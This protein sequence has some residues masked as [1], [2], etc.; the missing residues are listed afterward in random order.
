MIVYNVHQQKTF[1]CNMCRYISVKI[2]S[3]KRLLLQVVCQTQN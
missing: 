1:A 2:V 3:T